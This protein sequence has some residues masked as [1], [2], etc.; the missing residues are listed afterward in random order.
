MASRANRGG[1]RKNAMQPSTGG[2]KTATTC[3]TSPSLQGPAPGEI[4]IVCPYWGVGV[5]AFAAVRLDLDPS[6]HY[7]LPLPRKFYLHAIISQFLYL[8]LY[9]SS[10]GCVHHPKYHTRILRR[11]PY[12]R[13][14]WG[15]KHAKYIHVLRSILFIMHN[16]TCLD[17]SILILKTTKNP[18]YFLLAGANYTTTNKLYV[19]GS[20]AATDC[21]VRLLF[22]ASQTD[23]DTYVY[24][25][26]I[27]TS[28]NL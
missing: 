7:T 15:A 20:H 18:I 24:I 26:L 6:I 19:R 9:Y 27:P 8:C 22:F 17:R 3:I 5:F 12:V 13:Q 4:L 14:W 21:S 11:G 28:A 2:C 16:I 1:Q 25:W 10:C 23:A